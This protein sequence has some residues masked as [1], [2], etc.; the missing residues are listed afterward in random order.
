M[1]VIRD[2]NQL[3]KNQIDYYKSTLPEAD[4]KPG[5]VI[6]E[7]FIDGPSNQAAIIYEDLANSSSYNSFRQAVGND[8]D[9]LAS[10]FKKTRRQATPAVGI[11]LFTFSSIPAN[12]AINKGDLVFSDNGFSFQVVT[13]ITIKV[14]SASI[15][16]A[17]ANRYR[18]QLDFVGIS[19]TYAVE[20]NVVATTAGSAGKISKYSLKRTNVPSVSN[21]T[22]LSDFQG[23][24]DQ[25]SD[26]EFKNRVLASFSGSSVGTALGYLNAAISVTGVSD[27]IVIEPG[28]QLM[29]RD[30]T[31]VKNGEIIKEGSGGKVD[32]IVLGNA[33]QNSSDSFIYI[34]KSNLQD[35]TSTKNDVVLGQIS[36]DIN[37]TIFRKRI[38]DVKNGTLPNQPISS[39]VRVSGSLSGSNFK[40]KTID[41]FGRVS[42]NYEL[43]KDLGD[44]EGSPWASDSLHWISNTIS[45]FQEEKIKG[46]SN[47]QDKLSFSDV[48]S[49]SSV[50]Q[51]LLI[52]NESSA[53]DS[54]DRSIINLN[55]FPCTNVTRVFNA[56]TGERYVIKNQ[57]L[58]GLGVINKTG[59]I[60]ISGNN[61]PTPQDKL[62]VD[63]T[64]IVKFDPFHDFDGLSQTSN[65]RQAVD[66]VDWGYANKISER[67]L[68][69][70]NSD[71][72]VSNTKYPIQSVS[73][74]NHYNKLTG[75]VTK[76][77]SGQLTNR[78]K[79]SI[80]GSTSPIKNI[81]KAFAKTNINF[82]IWSTNDK[83]QT[84]VPT[85]Q[86]IDVSIVYG[87]DL[88][89]PTDV[90]LE[91][92]T[93]VEVW[94]NN[95]AISSIYTDVGSKQISLDSSQFTEVHD[96]INLEVNYITSLNEVFSSGNSQLPYYS[97]GLGYYLNT[98]NFN[99]NRKDNNYYNHF[100]V[101]R[102]LS[103]QLII[104][105]GLSITEY[106]EP[107]MLL[108]L[109]VLDNIQMNSD[110]ASGTWISNG[111]WQ[112]I[113]SG[114]N[115]P[116]ENDILFGIMNV[117]PIRKY[118]L[119]SF[120][121]NSYRIFTSK[122][123]Y[124]TTTDKLS[125]PLD[126][127]EFETDVVNFQII[128]KDN[129]NIIFSGDG[130]FIPNG[131][132]FDFVS[133]T[134][135]NFINTITKNNIKI[136]SENYNN[137]G[138]FDILNYDQ[139][140]N[141]L[142]CG[143]YTTP[144]STDKISVVKLSDGVQLVNAKTKIEN[145]KIIFDNTNINL[146]DEVVV[147]KFD[148]IFIKDGFTK[149]SVAL[150]DPQNATGV[151]SISGTTVHYFEEIITS[152]KNG[153]TQN[154]QE[155]ARK[156]FN[157]T[158]I[159][160]IKLMKVIN[161]SKIT[162][163]SSNSEE[164][165]TTDFTYDTYGT[166]L[167]SN[168]LSNDMLESSNLNDMEFE[169]PSSI[170]NKFNQI[171]LG[172]KLKVSGYF[173]LEND[174]ESFPFSKNNTLYS[175]KYFARIDKIYVSSGFNTTSARFIVSDFHQPTLGSRYRATYSYIAPKQ[176]E[177]ILIESTY[178]KLI[179]DIT[180]SVENSRPINADVL[181]KEAKEVK[182]DLEVRVV[183]DDNYKT[184]EKTI[185][186]SLKDKLLALLNSNKLNDLID[187]ATIITTGQSIQGIQR[188]RIIY[189]HKVGDVGTYSSI[190][191]QKNE[192]FSS[193]NIVIT[194]ETR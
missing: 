97:G 191:G 158:N 85:S 39:I 166:K 152:I 73:S 115:F 80:T 10:N 100:I 33:E 109:R 179:G 125:V 19:D 118:Q 68:F 149:I 60:K 69:K 132:K 183:I 126:K 59:R 116:N 111:T 185:L 21:V 2:L 12:L 169:L 174:T 146:N 34:D 167:K 138:L 9:K 20:V 31:V 187:V 155:A 91:E 136:F 170:H 99:S 194:T 88:I 139:D 53:L 112:F 122:L 114:I 177:R 1:P 41:E 57:N 119:Q 89:L 22:N 120:D 144:S 74:I 137:N 62:Q 15:Y 93:I 29:T 150:N 103:N 142:T 106:S 77:T 3:I 28:D 130:Y 95:Q 47:G 11:A 192:Y 140:N 61:L 87:A 104:D 81:Y 128:N 40:E 38:D 49:L 180:F 161:V 108:L 24:L 79:V 25:E 35:P 105:S 127:Y 14:S 193:N 159:S 75:V 55:H 110:L 76:V 129:N 92:G 113:L 162:T 54:L 27:A 148:P 6:R 107:K 45:N 184:N 5:S 43:K 36:T 188:V 175:N 65:D 46:Q 154:L 37:K 135:L 156:H 157:T 63:Y 56:T 16:K 153:L 160:Q 82:N 70:L 51:F 32:V 164:I 189:F 30:G 168:V 48:S 143:F 8:L 90:S 58:D 94:F 171:S 141:R 145:Q 131:L 96:E 83:N 147:L 173:V 165:L 176:N 190:Q 17:V 121:T 117:T 50:E 72:Y 178:N 18:D 42:G 102:N 64:W 67:L 124:D 172:N 44:Y 133:I 181:I 13:G 26:L 186:Q 23:G 182:L 7:L 151:M 52:T 66:V 123:T 4:T 134:N 101:T 71:F 163:V 84:F 86:L 78:L 98:K